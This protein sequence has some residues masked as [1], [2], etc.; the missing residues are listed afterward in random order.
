MLDWLIG[1]DKH[2]YFSITMILSAGVLQMVQKLFNGIAKQICGSWKKKKTTMKKVQKLNE[3]ILTK[4]IQPDTQLIPIVD[5]S[6][7]GEI[8]AC[9]KLF[10]EV[11][12]QVCPGFQIRADL[13]EPITDIFYWCIMADGKKLDPRKGLWLYGNI[14]TGKTTM[15]E[16][17]RRFCKFV[18]P[19]HNGFP[20]SFRTTNASVVCGEYTQNGHVGIATYINSER[21]AFDELGS[22]SI[23]TGYYGT[24][25]NVF[26]YILQRRYDNRYKSFTHVTT[27]LSIKQISEYYGPRIYDRCK[28]MFNFVEMGG[29]TWRK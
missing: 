24:P 26:Q 16:I 7:K 20:Y 11:A 6:K 1:S 5:S 23:P 27:N 21:Q 3:A 15:L 4:A 29:R 10:L 22:E 25:M 13:R 2:L 8:E 14:G 17:L 9:W 28:E 12:R 18:R 19:Y